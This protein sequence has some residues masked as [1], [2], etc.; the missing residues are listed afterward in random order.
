MKKLLKNNK[1]QLFF[2]ITIFTFILCLMSSISPFYNKL[3]GGTDS[4]VFRYGAMS[5]K[6]GL[7]PYKDFFDHKGIF[8]YIFNFIGLL[9]N[10]KFGV[11]I[12]EFVFMFFSLYFTH[13][14]IELFK[15]G[16]IK[17]FIILL[18]F[19][20]L[21]VTFEGGNFVEE[22]ALLPT[23]FSLYIFLKYYIMKKVKS[24]EI[25]MNGICFA[26]VCL[27]RVN[28]ISL[29]I[30]NLIYIFINLILNKDI[31]NIIKYTLSF[32]IGI[33]I[34]CLPCFIY[35]VYNNAFLHFINNY[36]IFNFQYSSVTIS[37]KFNIFQ[38]FFNINIIFIAIISSLYLIYN[39]KKNRKILIINFSC[40]I[41]NLLLMSMSGRDYMHYGMT[42][43][44][45][46]I[47]PYCLLIKIT[48]SKF[49]Q[50]LYLFLF[51]VILIPNSFKITE[52]IFKVHDYDNKEKLEYVK[53]VKENTNKNDRISVYGNSN[54]IYYLSDRLSASYY[55]YQ[56][57]IAFIDNN[58]FEEYIKDI[59]KEKPKIVV[60]IKKNDNSKRL[61]KLLKKL[62]YEEI[63]KDVYKLG[64]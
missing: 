61:I 32:V 18:V 11:W 12:V 27:L 50:Y 16:K 23:I 15:P 60:V 5:M 38:L 36:I 3:L 53:I 21:G 37:E 52:R 57:P 6:K 40:I 47:I 58:I 19:T 26:I 44:P 8:I 29:W 1:F 51:A 13:K 55:S 56:S 30:I 35:L 10:K 14:I 33:I 59:K 63:R 22:Y 62:G 9:I 2:F 48:N 7:I 39:D 28:M 25:V 43:I 20:F 54:Y 45:F 46:L 17:Y 4:F 64:E 34:V 49:R 31:K 42:M 24:I 41:L